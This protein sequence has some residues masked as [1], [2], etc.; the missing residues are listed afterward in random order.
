MPSPTRLAQLKEAEKIK[1]QLDAE[2]LDL[3]QELMEERHHVTA[4]E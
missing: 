2:K 1:E 3:E 4:L